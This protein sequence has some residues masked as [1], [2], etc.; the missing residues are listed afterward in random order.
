MNGGSKARERL[1][2]EGVDSTAFISC[3]HDDSRVR[4]S[5]DIQKEDADHFFLVSWDCRGDKQLN[6]DKAHKWMWDVFIKL[7]DDVG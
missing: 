1:K 5:I 4:M 6:I 2:G 3:R 7:T